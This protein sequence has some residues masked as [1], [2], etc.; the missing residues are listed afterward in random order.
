[1]KQETFSIVLPTFNRREKLTQL[2]AALLNQEYPKRFYE[3]IISDDGS[4]E[5]MIRFIN[6]K[7]TYI[8]NEHQGVIKTVNV[9][10]RKTKNEI[11]IMMCDDILPDENFLSDYNEWFSSH[12]NAQAI[13]ALQVPSPEMVKTNIFARHEYAV[14]LYG[15]AKGLASSPIAVRRE[16]LESIH[17]LDGLSGMSEDTRMIERLNENGYTPIQSNIEVIHMQ[18][19]SLR[20]FIKSAINRG[21]A[22]RE[23]KPRRFFVLKLLATPMMFLVYYFRLGSLETTGMHTIYNTILSF[24]AIMR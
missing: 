21:R 4:T 1:M 10:L 13:T 19:Y 14:S 7:I 2:L 20:G 22:G 9:G 15:F 16:A 23:F 3:I 8:E 18:D 24:S 11:V 6:K 12:P 17:Y 5:S